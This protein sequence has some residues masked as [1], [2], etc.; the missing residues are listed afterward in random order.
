MCMCVCVEHY[1]KCNFMCDLYNE[2][3]SFTTELL[4]YTKK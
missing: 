4:N 1:H 3:Q 2:S